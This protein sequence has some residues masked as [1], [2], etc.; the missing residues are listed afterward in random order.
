MMGFLGLMRYF[1]QGCFLLLTFI[2]LT[3]FATPLPHFAGPLM[4]DTGITVDKG[5]TDIETRLF[6][7]KFDDKNQWLGLIQITQGITSS[8][9]FQVMPSL[10]KNSADNHSRTN[11]GDTLAALGFQLVRQKS[12]SD[13]YSIKLDVGQ[14]IPTGNYR[15]FDEETSRVEAMSEGVFQTVLA[16]NYLKQMKLAN[17]H[18]LNTYVTSDLLLPQKTALRGFNRYGG[19]ANTHGTIRPGNLIDVD[20]ALEYQ[21]H[22]NII[23]VIEGLYTWRGKSSFSGF[24]GSNENGIV[25]APVENASSVFSLAPAIEYSFNKYIAVVAGLWFSVGANK[26]NTFRSAQLTISYTLTPETDFKHAAMT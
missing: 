17:N 14:I 3:C 21:L 22:G 24:A 19:T 7:S 1:R 8:V 10:I 23:G 5:D 25:E 26:E 15:H 4:A 12:M 18:I 9:D 11:S 16:I 13:G 2:G 6:Y 20:M